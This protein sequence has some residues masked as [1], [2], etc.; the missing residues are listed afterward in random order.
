[1]FSLKTLLLVIVIFNI[2]LTY[3]SVKEKLRQD[4]DSDVATTSL[5]VSLMCPV[6]VDLILFWLF[7]GLD[8]SGYQ[9]NIFIFLHKNIC[10]G[11]SLEAPCKGASIEYPQHMFLWRE[12]KKSILLV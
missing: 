8:K 3:F 5:R 7:I 1:M 9:V 6:N 10:C 11:Y 4:P 2:N 12:E